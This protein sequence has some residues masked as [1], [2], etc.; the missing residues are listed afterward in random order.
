VGNYSGGVKFLL[1]VIVLGVT[2]YLLVRVIQRRGISSIRGHG[3]VPRPR[4]QRRPLA[5]DDD[6]EFLRDLERKR[7]RG[8]DETDT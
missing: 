5:P 4:E 7:R 3:P 6:A 2:I 8:Q 1:V